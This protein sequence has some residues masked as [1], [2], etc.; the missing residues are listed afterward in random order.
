[1]VIELDCVNSDGI[2]NSVRGVQCCQL[3]RS[4]ILHRQSPSEIYSTHLQ[5]KLPRRRQGS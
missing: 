5:K 3:N 2:N 1:M 4:G